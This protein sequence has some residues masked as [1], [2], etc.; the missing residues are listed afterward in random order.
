MLMLAD[1]VPELF[2]SVDDMWLSLSKTLML[3][4]KSMVERF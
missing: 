4:L 3:D 1:D 2:C